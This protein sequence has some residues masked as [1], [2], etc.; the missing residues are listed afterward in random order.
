MVMVSITEEKN[1]ISIGTYHLY[2]YLYLR[3]RLVISSVKK[4][5]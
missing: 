3:T 2:I 1:S 5:K 4:K